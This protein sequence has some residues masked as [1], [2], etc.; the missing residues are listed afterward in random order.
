MS[1]GPSRGGPHLPGLPV[2]QFYP[3]NSAAAIRSRMQIVHTYNNMCS[4]CHKIRSD[5]SAVGAVRSMSTSEALMK[6]GIIFR[7]Q[8]EVSSLNLSG[9]KLL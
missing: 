9:L 4:M 3:G 6:A 5:A 7:Q 8:L 2:L 1:S